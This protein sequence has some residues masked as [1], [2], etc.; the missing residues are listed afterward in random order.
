MTTDR[1]TIGVLGGMA[2]ASTVEYYRLIDELINDELGGHQAG[3]ILIRSVNFADIE[4]CIR[5]EQ[6][7]EAG[8]RLATAAQELESGGADFI[9][10]ATN[11]MH[12]VAPVIT[13]AISIPFVHIIDVT[14]DAIRGAGLDT[15]GVLGTKTT[16]E[17][18]FYR[19]R[20]AEHGVDVVVP[21]AD[22]RDTIDTIIFEELTKGITRE[23][24]RAAYLEIIDGLVDSGADGLV[25]GCTEIELLIDQD[26]RPSLPMFDTTALHVERAVERSLDRPV[27]AEPAAE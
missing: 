13:D 3:E 5:E 14:A 23:E 10:M 8:D 17:A 1:E 18:P 6:W 26:D 4:R 19:E 9:I 25:L 21:D 2:S 16:M 22:D 15:V 24:S 12:K 7:E 11:T 20:F 27:E